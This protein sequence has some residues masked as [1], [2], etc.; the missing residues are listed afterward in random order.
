M[1]ATKII[2]DS[3][4]EFLQWVLEYKKVELAYA[5]SVHIQKDFHLKGWYVNNGPRSQ[6]YNMCRYVWLNEYIEITDMFSK[7]FSG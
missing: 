3:Q 4:R 1:L 2:T 6:T 7:L 5:W